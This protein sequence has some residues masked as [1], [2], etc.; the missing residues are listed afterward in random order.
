M[1]RSTIIVVGQIHSVFPNTE[2]KIQ[3]F[4]EDIKLKTDKLFSAVVCVTR[5]NAIPP[6]C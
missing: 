3:S 4:T 6:H 5:P 1:N 2:A